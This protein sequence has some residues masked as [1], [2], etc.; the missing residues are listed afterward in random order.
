MRLFDGY[1]WWSYLIEIELFEVIPVVDEYE[2]D[3]YY[4]KKYGYNDLIAYSFH[5]I[6]KSYIDLKMS[7]NE[8][9]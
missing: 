7:I 5:V 8:L 6:R 2:C 1:F 9:Y 3:G 4:H